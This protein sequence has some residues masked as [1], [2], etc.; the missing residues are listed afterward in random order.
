MPRRGADPATGQASKPV[1][2]H[3]QRGLRQPALRG[4]RDL[5][6][7][8]WTLGGGGGGGVQYGNEIVAEAAYRNVAGAG[9]DPVATYVFAT[10]PFPAPEGKRIASVRLPDDPRVHV[11]TLAVG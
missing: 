1:V 9:R 3:R 6:F 8:D 5:S 4:H 2:P 7:T 10:K 11:F